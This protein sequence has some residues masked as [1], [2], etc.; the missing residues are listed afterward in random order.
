MDNSTPQ[1]PPPTRPRPSLEQLGHIATVFAAL[2]GFV[3]FCW[4][5]IGAL[6]GKTEVI[7]VESVQPRVADDGRLILRLAVINNGAK[8]I[9]VR[10]VEMVPDTSGSAD[11]SPVGPALENRLTFVRDTSVEIPPGDARYFDSSAISAK[12]AVLLTGTFIVEIQSTRRQFSRPI[13]PLTWQEVTASGLLRSTSFDSATAE[14]LGV[15]VRQ[16]CGPAD[17]DSLRNAPT[18]LDS[19]SVAQRLLLLFLS[20]A[21]CDRTDSTSVESVDGKDRPEA[22][23]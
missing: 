7:V 11:R 8:A 3:A 1:T 4:Q 2:C 5:A 14:R 15:R 10:R 6:Q 13:Q 21:L 20:S 23:P 22:F 19:E 16:K 9:F 12:V 18:R 17:I